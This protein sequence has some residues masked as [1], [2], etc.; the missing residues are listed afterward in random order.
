MVDPHGAGERLP[1][2][3][4]VALTLQVSGALA[5]LVA[6]AAPGKPLRWTV[7]RAH[8]P[9]E[10]RLSVVGL[11]APLDEAHPAWA[12]LIRGVRERLGQL[13]AGGS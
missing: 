12:A 7:A 4:C 13:Q 11:P 9:R 10:G 6:V 8:A 2:G 3:W 5:L 1:N